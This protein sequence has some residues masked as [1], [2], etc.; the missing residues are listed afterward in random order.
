[1]I[2]DLDEN[3][4]LPPGIHGATMEEVAERFGCQ[5]ESRRAQMESL[6]WLVD[7]AA[8]AGSCGSSSTGAS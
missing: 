7:L 2:P 3:G 4:Y 6:R 1:M 5:S 8:R